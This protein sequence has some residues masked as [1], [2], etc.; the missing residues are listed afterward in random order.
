MVSM[1]IEQNLQY[2]RYR[3]IPR[4]ISIMLDQPYIF[5]DNTV[6]YMNLLFDYV[7][8]RLPVIQLG[9]ECDNYTIA[10]IYKH[11]DIAKMTF[12]LIEQ[13]E[14]SSGNVLGTMPFIKESLTVI[15]ALDQTAYI[16][17]T[18]L[19]LDER[20]DYAK[21]LQN[22]ECYLVDMKWVNWFN[23]KCNFSVKDTTFPAIFQTLF[24]SRNIPGNVIVASPPLQDIKLPKVVLPLNTLIGNIKALNSKYGL[25]DCNPIVFWDMKYLYCLNKREPN[26]HMEDTAT[27]F[28][29]VTFTLYNPDDDHHLIRGSFDD[30]N[31][32]THFINLE[33][34]P[35]IRDDSYQDTNTKTSTVITVDKDGAVNSDTTI[36]EDATKATYIYADNA[37]SKAQ[38]INEMITGPVVSVVAK[39]SSVRF[40]RPYKDYNFQVGSTYTNLNLTGK[41]FRLLQ[42]SLGIRREGSSGYLNDVGMVLYCPKRDNWEKPAESDAE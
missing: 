13:K 7:N 31:S 35:H 2:F 33:D 4:E 40:L 26:A 18:D 3:Y 5:R 34:P 20:T 8:N 15:P 19:E 11:K 28:G 41:T 37:L 38:V 30:P 10:Q 9:I 27:D 29:T 25:Y 14:D 17:D 16:T 36:D 24:F 6:L 32:S 23:A 22:F 12:T 42:Y 39:D 21:M 1:A